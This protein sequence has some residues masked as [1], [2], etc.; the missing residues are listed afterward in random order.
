MISNHFD[1]KSMTD[2][3]LSE[4]VRLLKSFDKFSSYTGGRIKKGVGSI[5]VEDEQLA[6]PF[7]FVLPADEDESTSPS[8]NSN[9]KMSYA[10]VIGFEIHEPVLKDDDMTILSVVDAVKG[11]LYSNQNLRLGGV[12][13]VVTQAISGFKVVSY[14]SIQFDSGDVLGIC[15]II[16]EYRISVKTTSRD[17]SISLT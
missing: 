10:I 14:D 9:I 13:Q 5:D 17:P 12:G 6:V 8:K 16:V 11:Y 3:G 15:P 1:K 7:C 2:Q 4:L